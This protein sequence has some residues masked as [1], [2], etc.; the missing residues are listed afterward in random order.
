MRATV[1]A[2]PRTAFTG[3]PSGAV[4]D[5]GSAWYERKYRLAASSS[6][7]GAFTRPACHTPRRGRTTD[8]RPR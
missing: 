6:T 7:S 4:I 2:N 1:S 3:I 8:T 5:S